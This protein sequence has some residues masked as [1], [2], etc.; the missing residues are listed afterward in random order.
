[1]AN[2]ASEPRK[3]LRDTATREWLTEKGTFSP[4]ISKAIEIRSWGQA[5][6][7]QKKSNRSLELVFKFARDEDDFVMPL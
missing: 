3:L 5:Y 4:E 6:E 7:L 2:D 1:M